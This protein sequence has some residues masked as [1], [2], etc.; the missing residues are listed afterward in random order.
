MYR[1]LG[2]RPVKINFFLFTLQL[3]IN[4][5][6]VNAASGKRFPTLNPATEEVICEVAEA[7]KVSR[8]LCVLFIDT[9]TCNLSNT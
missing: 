1:Y 2:L 3:F 7:D 6:W 9:C 4:N 8:I 5:E